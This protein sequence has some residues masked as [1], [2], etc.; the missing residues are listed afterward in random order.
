MTMRYVVVLEQG[1]DGWI[2]A[3]VPA[4]AGCHSQGQ[5]REEALQNIMEAVRGYLA[6]LAE[7]G[8]APPNPDLDAVMI[9]V[10]A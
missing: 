2:I 9:E 10:T 4:L 8:E 7:D 3:S 1:E 5:T 6:V